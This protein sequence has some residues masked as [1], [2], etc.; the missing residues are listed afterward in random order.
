MSSDE[1]ILLIFS[2]I[3][4][5]FFLVF[6]LLGMIAF[7]KTSKGGALTFSRLFWRADF[8]MVLTVILVVLTILVFGLK[9]IISENSIVSILSG[10]V[11]YVLGSY[12]KTKYLKD[13]NSDDVASNL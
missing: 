11:G 9:G 13:N 2:C 8:L 4:G 1:K 7:N 10:I 3:V 6:L 5:V 12:K